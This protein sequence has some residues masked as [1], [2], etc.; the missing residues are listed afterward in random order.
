ML[1]WTFFAE[2]CFSVMKIPKYT[3]TK[4]RAWWA[5]LQNVG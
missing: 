2:R 1:T 3:Y 4:I 5:S